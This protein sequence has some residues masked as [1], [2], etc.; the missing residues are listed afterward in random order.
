MKKTVSVLLLL[1]IFLQES[2]ACDICGCGVGSYYI[3]ILPDFSKKIL[4]LRYRY[5]S[6]KSHLGVNGSTTHLTTAETYQTAEL[7]GGWNLGKKFRIMATMPVSFND[8]INQGITKH[9]AGPG[10]ISLSGFYQ[11]LNK[12]NAA[13]DHQLLVQSLWVGAGIKLPTGSYDATDKQNTAT[14][15]NL[16]QLGTASTDFS[17]NLMY[18]IRLQDAG[19]NITGNYKMNTVNKD[20]YRYGNRFST[21]LQGYYKWR[22]SNNCTVAPNAGLLFEQGDTDTDKAFKVDMS[23]GK[24]LLATAGLETNIKKVS[25][26]ASYQAPIQQ[27]LA[28]GF[29]KAGNRFMLHVSFML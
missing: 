9:K 19:L 29:V 25:A 10:D 28:K 20:G 6:L 24:I 12:R 22:I 17:I 15:A 1:I 23:G 2:K 3:G 21:S 13:G 7:W 26:G 16:F 27:D 5:N 18:D 14:N 8:R 11:L 4:G